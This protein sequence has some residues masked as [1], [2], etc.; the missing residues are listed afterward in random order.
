VWG[1][2][3]LFL[4]TRVVKHPFYSSG[5]KMMFGCVSDHFANF[6]HVKRSKTSVSSLNAL[7]RGTKVV[8]RPFYSIGPKM[9]FGCV[10]KHFADL[11]HVKDAKLVF[12][13]E[14]TILG[15]QSCEANLDYLTQN[16]VWECFG[17][18]SNLRRVKSCETCV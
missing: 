3:A 8:K 4:G 7:F 5:P 6:R 9:I 15:Y 2:N 18:F 17:A 12:E 14:C 16:D 13:P 1:L 11:R 10:S